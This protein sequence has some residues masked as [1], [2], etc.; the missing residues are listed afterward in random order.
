MVSHDFPKNYS[1]QRP[2][3]DFINLPS[4]VFYT[5]KKT[6]IFYLYIDS[7]FGFFQILSNTYSKSKSSNI[8]FNVTEIR[9]DIYSKNDHLQ[10]AVR[11]TR[12]PADRSFMFTA[13]IYARSV[14]L[15]G[16]PQ[17]SY[18][19]LILYLIH[20]SQPKL[21]LKLYQPFRVDFI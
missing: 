2:M 8:T 17:F 15:P 9:K 11:M 10:S 19:V 18:S 3:H 7:F 5:S 14:T 16:R 12:D 13:I 21:H 6:I 1:V 4:R 20:Q